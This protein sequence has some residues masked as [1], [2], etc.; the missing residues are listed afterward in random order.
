MPHRHCA[1]QSDALFRGSWGRG[2]MSL[3]SEVIWPSLNLSLFVED[4]N[5]PNIGQTP[6][7]WRC[8]Q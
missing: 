2:I 3:L 4:Q 6:P 7:F 1:P 5:D 8:M